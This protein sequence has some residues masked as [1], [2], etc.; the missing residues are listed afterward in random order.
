MQAYDFT[1]SATPPRAD[2]PGSPGLRRPRPRRRRGAIAL[3]F[4][5]FMVVCVLVAALAINWS[6]LVTVQRHLR[7]V[8]DAMALAGAAM[9]P[10]EGS[11]R[12]LPADQSDDHAAA[13]AEVNRIR[14]ANLRGTSDSLAVHADDLTIT[15]GRV[16][17]LAARHPNRQFLTSP[18]YNAIRVDV[19]RKRD[20]AHPV[21]HLISGLAGFDPIDVPASSIAAIDD[22]VVGFRPLLRAA[23]P[24]LP[25]AISEAAWNARTDLDSNGIREAVL[26]LRN[27][28]PA[29]AA[30]AN[31]AVVDFSQSAVDWPRV[32]E[33]LT[34]GVRRDHLIDGR[35]GP[36]G[37]GGPSQPAP[38][39]LPAVL[40][41][42]S[43]SQTAA[44]VQR[45]N[46]IAASSD[47][48]RALPVFRTYNSGRVDV[49]GFVAARVLSA[50]TESPGV[51]TSTRLKLVLE[52][53]HLIHATAWTD[54]AAALHNPY[55]F[56]LCLLQ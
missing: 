47:P 7:Q 26:R 33:Q 8:G 28:D 42:P 30:G 27:S 43:D 20:G 13:L 4:V 11:L 10:D 16:P 18:P 35:L 38:L 1:T 52:P 15:P 9:L 34:G 17:N 51:G 41:T 49:I 36:A 22:Q 32:A 2:A 53:C 24:L 29:S 37:P 44:L 31:G 46:Q 45:L 5:V 50:D 40:Q 12:D 14:Q 19:L 55:I 39:S 54:A 48:R 56:K 23:A 21:Q 6:Y 3:L 25:L